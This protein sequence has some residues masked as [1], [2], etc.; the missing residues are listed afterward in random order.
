MAVGQYPDPFSLVG[1]AGVVSAEQ[2]PARIEPAFGHF[3]EDRG[4]IAS[5]VR[6][7]KAADVFR[8]D[9][10]RL[11]FIDH[12]H[13]FVEKDGALAMLEARAAPGRGQV[14]AGEAPND[15]VNLAPQ[16]AGVKCGDV[17]VQHVL[18]VRFQDRAAE[19]VQF[20]RAH[21]L[22]AQHAPGQDGTAGPGEKVQRAQRPTAAQGV[23]LVDGVGERHRG[24]PMRRGRG[25]MHSAQPNLAWRPQA[26]R[27]VWHDAQAP[28]IEKNMWLQ[29]GHMG[30]VPWTQ[31]PARKEAAERIG[32]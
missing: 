13:H 8:E 7:E 10:W 30:Q 29:F 15:D 26:K 14:L 17:P 1:R 4:E 19:L 27:G 6:I 32:L 18:A 25:R 22:P 21:R 11:R 2:M 23:E 16:R 5:F 31:I 12:P 3:V 24:P 20:H 28:D 9:D